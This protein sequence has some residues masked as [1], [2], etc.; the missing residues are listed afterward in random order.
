MSATRLSNAF[1]DG[2]VVS[3]QV[4]G[5]ISNREEDFSRLNDSYASVTA[6]WELGSVGDFVA[7][8]MTLSEA[9]VVDMIIGLIFVD[10]T[11]MQPWAVSIQECRGYEL[12]HVEL[13]VTPFT[14]ERHP[15]PTSVRIGAGVEGTSELDVHHFPR[16]AD[17]VVRESIDVRPGFS[18]LAQGR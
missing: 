15:E 17:Y 4:A 7:T 12:V 3:S 6:V 14:R 11:N 16:T 2:G 18:G 1:V 8:R 5:A 13:L 9:E 10:V